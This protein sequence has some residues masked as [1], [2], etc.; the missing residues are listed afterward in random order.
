MFIAIESAGNGLLYIRSVH[1]LSPT[2]RPV[3]RAG[4]DGYT[5]LRDHSQVQDAV[6]SE[7]GRSGSPS[8]RHGGQRRDSPAVA[9]Q[10][11]N[12]ITDHKQVLVSVAIEVRRLDEVNVAIDRHMGRYAEDALAAT[13]Q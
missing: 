2:K 5:T 13:E 6:S 3:P 12:P 10:Y 11:A 9:A 8:R 4:Q 1:D 7:V